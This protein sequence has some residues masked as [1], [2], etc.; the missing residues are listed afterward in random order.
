MSIV[1]VT[2]HMM[3][4]SNILD[5]VDGL[6]LGDG[7][8]ETTTNGRTGRLVIGQSGHRM[9]WIAD[10][11]SQLSDFGVASSLSTLSTCNVTIKGK[12]CV[13]S[14]RMVLKTHTY[15]L[16]GDQQRRWYQGRVKVIP[17]D[18]TLSPQSIALWYFGDGCVGGNGY[19]AYFCTD[20]FSRDDVSWLVCAL[21]STY[22]WAPT[23]TRKNRI[24]L[25]KS[26]DRKS[27]K[28]MIEP[29]WKNNSMWYS[30]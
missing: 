16:L 14:E 27:L 15:P 11:H 17:K 6:L 12:V 5:V 28:D 30:Q 1:C 24:L 9:P 19:R 25:L 20:G 2:L 3:N 29:Y 22:N 7:F 8:I 21:R 26:R 10:L 18:V 13:R 4:D 23:Q